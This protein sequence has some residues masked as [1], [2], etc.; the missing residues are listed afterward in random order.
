MHL[1]LFEPQ[2]FGALVAAVAELERH[3]FGAAAVEPSAIESSL[4][5]GMLSEDSGVQVLLA[6]DGSEVAGFAT[7]SLLYPAPEQRAQLFMK[8]LFVRQ[9]WRST[10]LGEKLMKHLAA[11]AVQKNCIRFDWTTE[12]TNKGAMSFYERLGA[13]PVAEKVYYRL[14][15]KALESLAGNV[16][17]QPNPGDA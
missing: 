17:S 6:L 11:F 8:D 4:R 13:L 5:S 3:Y 16:I 9:Q 1:Q 10:G 2:Y 14:T 7:F 12:R 15:G